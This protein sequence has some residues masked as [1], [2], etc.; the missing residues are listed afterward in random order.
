MLLTLIELMGIVIF[1][2]ILQK[3]YKIPSP[4]TIM[5]TVLIGM[6]LNIS[7]LTLNISAS[8]FDSL[9]LISLPLLITADALKLKW[10]DLKKHGFSLFWV[11]VV[12]V[13][14]SVLCGVFMD[15]LIFIGYILPVAAVVMLFCMISATDLVT[16]SAIFSNF[17]VP[18]KLK[19]L[20]EGESLFND[21]TALIVFSIALVA[22][23]TPE[24]VT[25]S[26][27]AIKSFSVIFGAVA[28]G[29]VF[30]YITNFALRLSEDSFVEATIILFFAYVSYIVAE[31]FHFSGILAVI[32]T[33]VIAN[34]FIQKIIHADDVHI[35]EADKANNFGLLK[36]A[37]TTKDN[38]VTILKSLDFVSMFASAILF[39]SIAAV[40]DLN[41][42]MQYKYE[43]ISVFIISTFIRGLMMLKFAV[44]SNNVKH[45]LSIQKHW[46]A[47]LTFAGS[48]GALSI[49][50]VHMIPNTFK[51]KE[52]F[53]HI[54]IGNILLSTFI[55]AFI[56]AGIIVKNKAKFEK[57]CAEDEAH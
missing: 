3:N 35:E 46:W 11:A 53:E 20:A 41:K 28:I 4:V 31:H 45:M 33:A 36:Y 44:L 14:L 10:E 15:K 16:V 56:L 27:I 1:A 51:F 43:I 25:F 37:V 32:V 47:V 49:V 48:K 26:F 40:A 52:M 55:Y 9:V 2:S 39:V 5:A 29:L 21:A 30:G 57:E 12:S 22:L 13:I 50:M 24:K 7:H 34:K 38:H 23:Q 6:V 17:K 8:Q 54:I 18:H 19:A 42:M